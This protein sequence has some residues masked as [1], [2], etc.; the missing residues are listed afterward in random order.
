MQ[1]TCV[2]ECRSR[3]FGCNMSGSAAGIFA[4]SSPL[5]RQKDRGQESEEGEGHPV[6]FCLEVQSSLLYLGRKDKA[7]EK[8]D[9]AEKAEK[10]EKPEKAPKAGKS[11]AEKAD[12]E[13]ASARAKHVGPKNNDPAIHAGLARNMARPAQ[14]DKAKAEKPDKAF[15][16]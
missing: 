2:K 11:K 4:S 13:K 10:P 7:K 15:L 6:V 3:T 12:G 9:K 16:A 8:P 14:A 1:P 5:P